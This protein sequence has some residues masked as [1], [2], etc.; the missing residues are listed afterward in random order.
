MFETPALWLVI[1]TMVPL[2]LYTAWSD[3]KTLKIPNWIPLLILVIYLITGFWGLSLEVF[4]WGLGAG[5]I[6]LVAFI[7]L[8]SLLDVMGIGGI[9]AGDLKLLAAV[10]PFMFARDLLMILIFYFIA[11]MAVWMTFTILWR[12]KKGESSFAS[13]NQEGT[14]YGRR[15]PP[16]GVAIA[17]AMIAYL[18]VMGLRA[19][20]ALSV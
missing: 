4:L 16:M 5:V 10:V 17:G 15:T 13:L 9:G 1:A 3:L 7:L 11:V 12:R 2:L 20:G 8:Y 19:Q 6:T 14:K 18:I